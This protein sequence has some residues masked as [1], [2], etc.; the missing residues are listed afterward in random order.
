MMIDAL[1]LPGKPA[2]SRKALGAELTVELEC[3]WAE[4]LPQ[5]HELRIFV[6]RPF[7]LPDIGVG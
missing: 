7:G 6:V 4:S 5:T 1:H 3:R 2:A